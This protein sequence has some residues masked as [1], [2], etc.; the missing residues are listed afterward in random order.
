M[1]NPQMQGHPIALGRRFIAWREKDDPEEADALADWLVLE[2]SLSWDELL[3]R[4]RVVVLAEPG[5][6]KTTELEEQARVLRERRDF[7]F[8]ATLQNIGQKGFEAVLA[9]S[10]AVLTAWRAS[11][12]PAWFFLDSVDEAKNAQVPLT[13]ALR[14]V[15]LGITDCE[16]R[17]H[18]VLSG[19]HTDW[20]FRRDLMDLER[21]LPLP[22]PDAALSPIDPDE[23]LVQYMRHEEPQEAT[24]PEAPLIVVMAPLTREQVEIFARG[25]GVAEPESFLKATEKADLWR[26]ARR[27]LDLQWLVNSWRTQGAFGSFHQMLELSLRQRLQESNLQRARSDPLDSQRAYH[28]LTR[29]GAA[30]MLQKL[31]YVLVPDS[32]IDLG[33]GRAGLALEAVLPEWSPRDRT[34]LI[35]RAVFDPVVAGMVRLHQ[36]NQGEVRSY[37][38]A[39]WLKHLIDEN[40]PRPTI[41]DLLFASTYGVE[42]VIPSMRQTAAWLALWDPETAR[43]ILRRDPGLLMQT[44]DPAGLPLAVREE[45]LRAVIVRLS[46]DER[47]GAMNH[48]HLSRFARA[49]MVPLIRELWTTYRS[50]PDVRKLL[51]QLIWL[52]ALVDCADLAEEAAFA[53]ES[54]QLTQVWAGQALLATASKAVR[55]KYAQRVLEKAGTLAP[56][57]VWEALEELFPHEIGVAELLSLLDKVDLSGVHS[58]LD[59]LAGKLALRLSDRSSLERLLEGLLARLDPDE[60]A[61]DEPNDSLITGIEETSERLLSLLGSQETSAVALEGVLQTGLIRRW[62]KKPN[63]ALLRRIRASAERRRALFW[64]AATALAAHPDLKGEP[65]SEY[66]K[67][68]ALGFVPPLELPDVDWLLADANERQSAQERRLAADTVMFLRQPLSA[69]DSA[70]ERLRAIATMRPEVGAVLTEWVSPRKPSSEERASQRRLARLHERNSIQ[71]A[72]NELSWISFT[73]KIRLNPEQLREIP[74][75]T[76]TSMDARLYH[77]WHLLRTIGRNQNRYGFHSVQALAPVIGREALDPL[78][79]AF[80]RFWRHWT[81]TLRN[82]RP[83]GQ[84]NVIANFDSIGLAGVSLEAAASPQWSQDL[85]ESEASRAAGYAT[86]ELN[87]FPDWLTPLAARWPNAVRE[88]LVSELAAELEAAAPTPEI[89]VLQ[90]LRH[91]GVELQRLVAPYLYDLL[92]R[93]P[94]FPFHVLEYVLNILTHGLE[95]SAEFARFLLDRAGNET[96]LEH[97]ASYF[98][99]AF[100][101]APALTY[102][103]LK[104]LID[105]QKQKERQGLMQVIL[106]RI[107]GGAYGENAAALQ[108]APFETLVSL[109]KLAY[110]TIRMKEDNDHSDG[111]AYRSNTRDDAE[112]ARSVLFRVLVET[113]GEATFQALLR[114]RSDRDVGIPSERL[115]ELAQNRAAEDSEFSAW[116]AEEVAAFEKDHLFAP[117]NPFDLQR[118]VQRRLT[119]M[120]H[121]LLNADLTQGKTLARQPKERDVQLWIGEYLETRRGRSY[122]VER[123]SRVVNENAPDVRFRAKVSDASVP[124]EI[125]VAETWTLPALEEALAEQL[126]GRYLRDQHN[127]W[128]ILLLVHQKPKPRGWRRGKKGRLGVAEVLTHLRTKASRIAAARPDAPQ[129]TVELVDVSVT[130]S[131]RV[132]R[133]SRRAKKVSHRESAR[134]TARKTDSAAKP[135]AK[136]AARSQ[137]GKPRAAAKRATALR[138]TVRRGRA[139][140]IPPR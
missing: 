94:H 72:Q 111:A 137:G 81:P 69:G 121:D 74:P 47:A 32:A 13:D 18:I 44:G 19:R 112:G 29:I 16:G 57:V 120:Q 52:G 88:V 139:N 113:P 27:P 39:R 133:V 37:L 20:E 73:Q 55:Q 3:K 5:A 125:K 43:E 33:E 93:R 22:P 42:L 75:P 87:G 9:P 64:H 108:R 41:H 63:E 127:R 79:D 85:T 102:T 45:L 61:D 98:E 134:I 70:V 115:T 34:Y 78:R 54:D 80:I 68:R 4:R 107:C 49:D 26:F 58:R 67:F 129:P 131:E 15:A 71:Q 8:L 84:R 62:R 7:V 59:R 103:A 76:P 140:R 101:L 6:G 104:R 136:R 12:K 89:D 110:R 128:G 10:A 56:A 50:T 65:L 51:L 48:D 109:I 53:G 91:A 100:Q 99:Y 82:A 105:R 116:A 60:E 11:D 46:K 77:L 36:D 132:G 106:V 2:R 83:A 135:K 40:C 86:L 122:S 14:S 38:A 123:E 138:K 35:N 126:V 17:A 24:P 124:M 130:F 31:R 90:D 119:S 66:W 92:K 114:F 118:L 21:L 23:L 1:N 25:K 30:L 95:D 97:R 28:A 117:R 96:Y